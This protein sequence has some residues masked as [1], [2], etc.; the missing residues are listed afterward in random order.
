MAVNMVPRSVLGPEKE[1]VSESEVMH[2]LGDISSRTLDRWIAAGRFPR[3]IQFPGGKSQW[4]W[5]DLTWF[6]LGQEM[7]GR[8]TTTEPDDESDDAPTPRKTAKAT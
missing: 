8:L 3:G 1:W 7:I 5:K 4:S 6:F 2:L